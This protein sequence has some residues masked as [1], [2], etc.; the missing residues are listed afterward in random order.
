[1]D[2]GCLLCILQES[3]STIKNF[4]GIAFHFTNLCVG[5]PI[6][7]SEFCGCHEGTKGCYHGTI[8]VIMDIAF[9]VGVFMFTGYGCGDASDG[10]DDGVGV[11]GE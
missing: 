3:F 9:D 6:S 2:I 8:A 10:R 7:R 11:C 5:G 1:M 4:V